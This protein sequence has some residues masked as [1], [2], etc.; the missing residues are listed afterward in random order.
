MGASQRVLGGYMSDGRGSRDL[1]AVGVVSCMPIGY[2]KIGG[3]YGVG[4]RT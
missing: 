2:W 3:R 4:G 1:G